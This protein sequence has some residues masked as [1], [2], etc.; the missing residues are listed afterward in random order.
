MFI[1]IMP[2]NV[3]DSNFNP[4]MSIASQF[5]ILWIIINCR[6]TINTV[7]II[8]NEMDHESAQR[9]SRTDHHTLTNDHNS[10][11]AKLLIIIKNVMQI[12]H[13][14]PRVKVKW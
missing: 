5:R 8:V 4:T 9:Y 3:F 1:F 12:R 10:T 6:I 13:P 11:I 7:T 2:N 14:N